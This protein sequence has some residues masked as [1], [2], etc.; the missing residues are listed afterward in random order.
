MYRC[1]YILSFQ[2]VE[3]GMPG[4]YQWWYA[5]AELELS[6]LNLR[7]SNIVEF[8]D[9]LDLGRLERWQLRRDTKFEVIQHFLLGS[10]RRQPLH[11]CSFHPIV[12][13]LEA[14][15]LSVKGRVEQLSASS[16]IQPQSHW[17]WASGHYRC[18]GKGQH[19]H[20]WPCHMR[21]VRLG[22]VNMLWRTHLVDPF[23]SIS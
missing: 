19:G 17:V 13:N 16:I 6:E 4:F 18:K 5:C 15:M 1:Y 2:C 11:H 9:G 23:V 10:V 22:K 20:T 3:V 7:L 8:L 21:M 12:W 14:K